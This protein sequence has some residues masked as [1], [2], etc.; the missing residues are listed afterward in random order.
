MRLRSNVRAA[1]DT[2][3]QIKVLE[4]ENLIMLPQ[5]SQSG[6]EGHGWEVKSTVAFQGSAWSQIEGVF[7]SLLSFLVSV[8]YLEC[9][10]ERGANN[11]SPLMASIDG[12]APNV[13]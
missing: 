4:V 1:E 12:P 6:A 7:L 8:C 9:L 10:K 13:T 5:V 3:L 11:R 2:L